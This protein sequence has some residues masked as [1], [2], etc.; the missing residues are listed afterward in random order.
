MIRFGTVPFR[1]AAAPIILIAPV[2]TIVFPASRFP[3]TVILVAVRFERRAG[4]RD[5]DRSMRHQ[6]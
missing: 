4:K 3:D 1:L 5:G 6:R 2:P